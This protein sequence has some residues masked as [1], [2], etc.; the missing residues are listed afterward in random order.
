[1]SGASFGRA[2]FE[3]AFLETT[4]KRG[5]REDV[6]SKCA[7]Q[8]SLLQASLEKGPSLHE[9]VLSCLVSKMMEAFFLSF[10]PRARK[11]KGFS[12]FFL[13]G[14]PVQNRPQNPASAG[15]LFSTFYRKSRSEVPERGEFWGRKLAEE[16]WG[17]QGQKRKK[18]CTKKGGFLIQP[19]RK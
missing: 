11:Q 4:R 17:G 8:T 14:D 6:Q 12:F 19:K 2:K 18:G 5:V 1:M 15:G 3:I 7:W 13:W 9:H 10:F 16:G